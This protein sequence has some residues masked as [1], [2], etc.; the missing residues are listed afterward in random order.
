MSGL[1]IPLKHL[2]KFL[3]P[4]APYLP[5]YHLSQLM[6]SVFGYQ[7]RSISMLDPLDRPRRL[8]AADARR[9]LG[10]LPPRRA[11]RYHAPLRSRSD[12]DGDSC[13]QT[14]A[15]RIPDRIPEQASFPHDLYGRADLPHASTTAP[16]TSGSPTPSS[17]SSSPSPATA[18]ATGCSSCRIYAV[19][20]ALYIAYVQFEQRLPRLCSSPP[21]SCSASLPCPRTSA[22]LPSSSTSPRCCPSASRPAPCCSARSP[23]SSPPSRLE[24]HFF[25]GN[26]YNY[27]ITG[28]FAVVV[29]ISNVFVAQP[30]APTPNSAAPRRK[31]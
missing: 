18:D 26:P 29:G 28:F 4:I 6:L 14:S 2:P 23:P 22:L 16:P 15:P 9:Q 24:N 5:A 13:E 8:H 11:G 20:L 25:P 31:M 12:T 17:S 1:W 27:L 21:C 3:R 30:S 19:F 7:V 10:C